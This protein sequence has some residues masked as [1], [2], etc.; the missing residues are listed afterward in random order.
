MK[1]LALLLTVF[2]FFYID[3]LI[4][5]Y[6]FGPPRVC[7]LHQDEWRTGNSGA[8]PAALRQFA[9][10]GRWLL[11]RPARRRQHVWSLNGNR[12]DA[13]YIYVT[14][15]TRSGAATAVSIDPLRALHS[16]AE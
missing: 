8:I 4:V 13:T 3:K 14:E 7:D 12:A 11:L 2:I 16:P 15:A 1:D 6:F 9:R 10:R 5:A